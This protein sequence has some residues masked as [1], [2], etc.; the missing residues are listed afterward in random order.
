ANHAGGNSHLHI[1]MSSVAAAKAIAARMKKMGWRISEAPWAGGVAPIHK[2]PGHYSGSSFDANTDADET[3]AEVAAVARL[4][5]GKGG[6][7]AVAR[8]AKLMLEGPSGAL[9][10]IGQG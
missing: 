5:S 7:L 1:A 6:G 9:L 4:L 2:D 8:L 10:D 3:R